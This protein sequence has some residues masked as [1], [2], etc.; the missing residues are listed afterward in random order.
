MNALRTALLATLLLVSAG[1]AEPS[2]SFTASTEA[3]TTT[4]TTTTTTIARPAV[5]AVGS[6]DTPD[7]RTRTYRTYVPAGV[8]TAEVPLVIALHGGTGSGR[9]FERSSGL[10]AQA[11][12]Y[13]FVVVYPDGVGTGPDET[14]LRTWNAGLCCGPA[15]RNG[16]DDVAFI[17]LLIDRMMADHFIDPDRVFVVG[18]SNGGFMA[19]RLACEL[20]GRI[21]AVG[22]QAGGLGVDTCEPEQPVSLLHL[23]GRDDTN[24]RIEGGLGTGISRVEFPPLDDSLATVAAA[25]GCAE[26]PV[27]AVE[28]DVERRTWDECDGEVTVEVHVVDGRDHGWM[29]G[30]VDAAATIVEFLLAQ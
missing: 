21:A 16:V 3:T 13:G 8:G 11:D 14:E 7:G 15:S 29:R 1:C 28:G 22:L 20:S 27:I 5:P 24:V 17:G 25:M 6:I 10:D 12:Q 19:Y 18:H 23:H 4:T 26:P 30:D 9:Q 2:G